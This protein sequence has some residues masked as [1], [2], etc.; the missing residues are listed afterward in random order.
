[1]DDLSSYVID[2]AMQRA[3]HD[4][5]GHELIVADTRTP[6]LSDTVCGRVTIS[7]P[8][9]YFKQIGVT[10][11]TLDMAIQVKGPDHASLPSDLH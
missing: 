5:I 4:V 3:D 7:D 11:T 1:V 10:Q 2:A 9:S 6:S 8:A